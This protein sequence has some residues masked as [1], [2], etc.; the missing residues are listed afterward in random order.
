MWPDDAGSVVLSV[1][2]AAIA[3]RFGLA[4]APL[5]A[6]QW[7]EQRGASFV[8]LHSAGRLRGCIGTIEP[9]RTIAD[10]VR[11]NAHNA[12]FRDP[13]FQPVSPE[14]YAGLELEVSLLSPP[15]PM[16][17]ADEEDLVNQLRPGSDGVL[18]ETGRSRGTFLPQVW[19]QL[20]D[21]RDFVAHLKLKAGVDRRAWDPTWQVSRYSVTAWSE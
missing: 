14:E 19:E 9:Y 13:R 6:P 5:P 1:A 2:R 18:L 21:P 7:L 11:G 4:S 3:E 15:E 10:D 12:A 17:C 16:H 8:T 20:R